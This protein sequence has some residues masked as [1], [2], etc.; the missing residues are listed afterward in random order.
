MGVD[1]GD[2]VGADQPAQSGEPGDARWMGSVEAVDGD[3]RLPD[4]VDQGVL[5]RQEIGDL[6]PV[7]RPIEVTH[8][9]DEQPLGASAT[10]PF[11]QHQDADGA[12]CRLLAVHTRIRLCPRD[13]R[14]YP[15][16]S[17]RTS[18]HWAP[19]T[20]ISKRSRHRRRAAAPIADASPSTRLAPAARAGTSPGGTTTP[21][22]PSAT[23]S[24]TAPTSN[25]T[26]GR[27]QSPAS[28][29]TPGI[30]SV[31]LA[32]TTASAAA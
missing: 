8:G 25:A 13:G 30:P 15:I 7:A 11:G 12:V 22:S 14:D 3:S 2:V 17:A 5:P 31:R 20:P 16:N 10:Q 19:T 29:S 27:P 6:D 28:M 32:R 4:L 24:A 18:A 26:A 23:I 1:D 21:V 9:V